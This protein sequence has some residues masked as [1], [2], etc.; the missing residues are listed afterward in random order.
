MRG[1]NNV[2][3]ISKHIDTIIQ[4]NIVNNDNWKQHEGVG[5]FSETA[6]KTKQSNF[7]HAIAYYMK[8]LWNY[9][10]MLITALINQMYAR[11]L[12][13]FRKSLLYKYQ[14]WTDGVIM[15]GKYLEACDTSLLI[16]LEI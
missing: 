14:A 4:V 15:V 5:R 13:Y 16:A 2:T 11:K 12:F 7:T 9:H 10:L 8:M 3:Q 6:G 1:T